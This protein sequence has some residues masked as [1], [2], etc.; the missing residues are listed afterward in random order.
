VPVEQGQQRSRKIRVGIIEYEVPTME[1][2]HHLE[3][4]IAQQTQ[5]LAQLRRQIARMESGAHSTRGYVRRHADILMRQ[6]LARKPNYS[7]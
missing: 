3:Q 7:E 1:Y 4:V 6:E 2:M 5:T